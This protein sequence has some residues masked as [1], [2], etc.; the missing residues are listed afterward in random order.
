MSR[1]FFLFIL[2]TLSGCSLVA[3]NRSYVG[4]IDSSDE[5]FLVPSRD[6]KVVG[7]DQVRTQRSP[8]SNLSRVPE[9]YQDSQFL[10]GQKI[11]F[12]ELTE[13]EENLSPEEYNRYLLVKNRIASIS[14]KIQYLRSMRN[15]GESPSKIAENDERIPKKIQVETPKEE[16]AITEREVILGMSKQAVTK[17]WG[18]PMRVDVAGNPGRE[19][20]RWA[21]F[22]QGRY[23]YIFFESGKVSGWLIE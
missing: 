22:E 19:N 15:N 1:M 3:P 10:Q 7:G 9:D 16:Q 11:L 14:E 8:S 12:K 4:E 23:K 6:F 5:N 20:E 2:G 21:F 13:L 18:R 17:S